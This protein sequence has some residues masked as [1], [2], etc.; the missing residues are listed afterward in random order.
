MS[1]LTLASGAAEFPVSTEILAKSTRFF[2]FHPDL[3][4]GGRYHVL[5][6]ISAANLKHF[7]SSL[8]NP[9]AITLTPQNVADLSS[10]ADEFGIRTW[11]NRCNSFICCDTP[12]FTLDFHIDSCKADFQTEISAV[13]T[14][15]SANRE[16]IEC[17]ERHLLLVTSHYR[18]L[19]A[20]CAN[21]AV[22]L[23]E[24]THEIDNLK[25][26]FT[27][28]SS[29]VHTNVHSL[30]NIVALNKIQCPLIEPKSLDGIISYLTDKYG[31]NVH[32]KGIVTI[33]S[34]SL[35]S[36]H[37]FALK[38]VA[39]MK[40]DSRFF[41]ENEPHQWICW[42]FREMRVR[43]TNYT[44]Q[45][46]WLKSWVVEGSLDG[47]SWVEID[48]QVNNQDFRTCKGGT[49][50]FALA[51]GVDCRFVRL[52]QVGKAS[53]HFD[54]DFLE[55]VAFELFGTLFGTLFE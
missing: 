41:S 33:T 5:S 15:A 52:A 10:F 46:F 40:C 23:D 7:T 30:H 54:R 53:N 38:N 2:D 49:A 51:G 42:D 20:H 14:I 3:C 22:K 44:V 37:R 48:R 39:D 1:I 6:Q 25:Q 43:P 45:S 28:L 13:R 35:I 31:G 16:A 29:E 21:Q 32:E 47:E 8:S 18:S 11:K 36:D 4:N 50:S 55:L 24:I 19:T 17:L 26:S 12:S 27:S 9:S 34:K